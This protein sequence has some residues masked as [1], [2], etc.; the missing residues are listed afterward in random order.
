MTKQGAQV[1]EREQSLCGH[2]CFVRVA[3]QQQQQQSARTWQHRSTSRWG[4]MESRSRRHSVA[5][6]ANCPHHMGRALAASLMATKGCSQLPRQCPCQCQVAVVICC[7]VLNWSQPY[8]LA[9]LCPPDSIPS[10]SWSKHHQPWSLRACKALVLFLCSAAPPLPPGY[11]HI[12]PLF[13]GNVPAG[14]NC[15]VQHHL[16]N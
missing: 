12:L 15:P 11:V 6:C 2:L 10:M 4:I 13:S 3:V 16:I 7:L 1:E 5:I 8:I 9:L 14:L